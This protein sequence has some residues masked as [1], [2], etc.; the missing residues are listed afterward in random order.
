MYILGRVFNWNALPMHQVN[1]FEPPDH[2]LFPGLDH[3]STLQYRRIV[4]L[5]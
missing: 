2:V 5:F 3:S 1:P 4:P